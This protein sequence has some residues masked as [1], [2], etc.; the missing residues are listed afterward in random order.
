[1]NRRLVRHVVVLAAVFA[2]AG[3]RSVVGPFLHMKPDYSALPTDALREVALDIE[4]AV[5][6]GDRDPEIADRAGIVVSDEL[7]VQAI[8]TRAARSELIRLFLDDGHG[9]ELRNGLAEIAGGKEYKRGTTSKERNRNALL[10]MSENADRWTIYEGI[11]KANHL[12][13]RAL[14]A[15]QEVFHEARLECMS[16][17][18]KYEDAA[19]QTAIKGR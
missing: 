8:R 1:M 15:I 7:I 13:P 11:I 3:C 6:R 19:G 18:Q 14:S 17:G 4:R 12:S 10:I 16:P 2:A 5:Q 9:R